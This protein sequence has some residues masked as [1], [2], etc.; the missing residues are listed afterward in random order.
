MRFSATILRMESKKTEDKSP[1]ALREE[2]I[3]EFWEKAEVFGKTLEKNS[4]KGEFVF[5][6]GPPTANGAPGIHHLEA[7]VFK[8]LFHDIRQCKA[9]L[10]V[11][12]GD[13]ILTDFR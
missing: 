13:G 10:S 3:L 5:Y 4:P 12:K 8:D 1:N 9:S 7:R 11:E 2:R 6:E